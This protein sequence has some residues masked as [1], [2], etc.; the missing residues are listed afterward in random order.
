MVDSRARSAP[1]AYGDFFTPSLPWGEGS[2]PSEGLLGNVGLSDP[3]SS[4]K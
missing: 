4:P 2:E 3:S 1:A